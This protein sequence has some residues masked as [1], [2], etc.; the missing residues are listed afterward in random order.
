MTTCE[1]SF[2]VWRKRLGAM[3]PHWKLQILVTTCL[4]AS[5]YCIDHGE[6]SGYGWRKMIGTNF[7]ILLVPSSWFRVSFFTPFSGQN[8]IWL[9][10]TNKSLKRS[11]S[12][13]S[14]DI[15]KLQNIQLIPTMALPICAFGAL[16]L[17]PGNIN[18]AQL[19]FSDSTLAIIEITLLNKLESFQL[20]HGLEC[21]WRTWWLHAD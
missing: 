5:R 15:S 17:I 9:P 12:G 18:F 6:V 10:W 14:K 8:E 4:K 2:P 16:L 3:F 7:L 11:S 21:W 13:V 19:T 20:L 1:T